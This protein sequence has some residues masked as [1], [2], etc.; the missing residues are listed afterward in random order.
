MRETLRI[1]ENDLGFRER[2]D[3]NGSVELGRV[4]SG[5]AVGS[6]SFLGFESEDTEQKDVSFSFS[7]VKAK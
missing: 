7:L 3:T 2:I 5:R 1:V 6:D 4:V